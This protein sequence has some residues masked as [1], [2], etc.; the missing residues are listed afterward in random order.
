VCWDDR[1]KLTHSTTYDAPPAEVYAMLTDREFRERAAAATGV[2]SAEVTVEPRGGG[3][4]VT[5]DQVQPTAGLPSF[6]KKITG[7]TTR[8]VVVETWSDLSTA[9]VTIDTP[10]KPSKV[11]GTY[12]LR[13]E[14]GGTVQTFDGELKVSVPLVGG[15]LEKLLADLFVQGREKEQAAGAEWLAE[16]GR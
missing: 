11:S 12:S 3:H 6:A 10:G 8:A 4:V 5:V 2:V 16:Q 7:D 1:M 9:T 14:G 15:K 13:E